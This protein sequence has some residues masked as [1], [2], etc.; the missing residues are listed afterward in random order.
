MP[1]MAKQQGLV[2]EI[3]HFD[4]VQNQLRVLAEL[5]KLA[6]TDPP[7]AA[8]EE[9]ELDLPLIDVVNYSRHLADTRVAENSDYQIAIVYAEGTIISGE[10][11]RGVIGSDEYVELLQD[12]REDEDVKAVVLRINSPGG[13]ATA[14][15]LIEREVELLQQTKPVIVS[16]GDI[17]AS[18]G[19]MIAA[20]AQRILAQ[21][22]TIT[23]SIGVFGLLPNAQK[24]ANNNGITWDSLSTGPYA[25]L[26]TIARPRTPAEMK[27][28]QQFV[29]KF[30][31]DF[32]GIVAQGRKLTPTAVEQ[33]AQGRVWSGI[34]AQ[35]VKLVDELGGLEMAI[36]QAVTAAALEDEDWSIIEYPSAPS[37][38]EEIIDRLF[39]DVEISFFPESTTL[40]PPVQG[41]AQ[42]LQ[43]DWE[44]LLEFSDPRQIYMRLP[45]E[46]N[47][48]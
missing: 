46:L 10:G 23:G 22:N 25:N 3:Q 18:G 30:Y 15:H 7:E 33:V 38:E 44:L 24:L 32:V 36:D 12:L 27:L 39:G 9:A 21:P 41:L 16:M 47:V 37:L 34:A 17:A 29:D 31:A 11:D 35:R 4:E 43:N 6:T 2:D 40:L 13:S 26:Y 5:D 19:Y 8:E 45:Y 20:P 28:L 14:S 48:E 1:E 42:A